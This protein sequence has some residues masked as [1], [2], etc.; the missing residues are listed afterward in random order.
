MTCNI[1]FLSS[2][3]CIYFKFCLVSAVMAPLSPSLSYPSI[4]SQNQIAIK[5][6]FLLLIKIILWVF[7]LEYWSACFPVSAAAQPQPSPLGDRSNVS[8]INEPTAKVERNCALFRF[9]GGRGFWAV[10][11]YRCS[12]WLAELPSLSG[13]ATAATLH[14]PLWLLFL[15]Q[16]SELRL[17]RRCS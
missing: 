7:F 13:T 2:Y 4:S 12:H 8:D 14:L 9:R 5:N 10:G 11:G 16:F 1:L 6:A 3:Y 15:L 17:V